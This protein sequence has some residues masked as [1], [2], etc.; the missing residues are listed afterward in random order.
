M[1]TAGHDSSLASFLQTISAPSTAAAITLKGDSE[2]GWKLLL[3]AIKTKS[4]AKLKQAAALIGG[5][6]APPKAKPA[7][8]VK[9]ARKPSIPKPPRAKPP[10][11]PP[12]RESRR[13]RVATATGS[14]KVRFTA[15][16]VSAKTEM[17][18]SRKRWN[19]AVDRGDDPVAA[20]VRRIKATKDPEKIQSIRKMVEG[21]EANVSSREYDDLMLAVQGKPAASK[22]KRSKTKRKPAASKPRKPAATRKTA[23]KPKPRKTPAKRKP[24]KTPARRPATQPAMRAAAEAAVEQVVLEAV[25]MHA[26]GTA[27]SGKKRVRFAFTLTPKK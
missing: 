13:R 12:I 18:R 8:T 10:K 1:D 5:V 11:T 14:P 15:K 6:T 20:T 22:P 4:A 7:K 16:Q 26:K 25:K 23:A 24:R 21:L 19:D 9:P 3:A 27:I 17:A 2:K